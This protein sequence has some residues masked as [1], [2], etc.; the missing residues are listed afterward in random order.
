MH[1]SPEPVLFYHDDAVLLYRGDALGL[2]LLT[3]DVLVTDPPYTR[4][5]SS[6]SG[7]TTA[8][9]RAQGA[10]EAD[11]FW[12]S[13][14][15][16][17]AAQIAAH[18]KPSGCGFVFTDFRTIHLVERAFVN[19]DSGWYVGQALVWDRRSLGLGSPFR[20]SHEMIA[21]CRGPA[22][23]WHGP[24]DVANVLPFRWPYGRH[25]HHPA[26]KPL[27]LLRTLIELITEPGQVVLDLFAGSGSTLLAA[28]LAGR[29]AIGCEA[30]HAYCQV[31]SLRLSLAA[32][33]DRAAA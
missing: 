9:G 20:A 19:T 30:E 8:V 4:T 32:G 18:V 15:T 13:W 14:F 11:Q 3:A 31:A 6:H 23:R 27:G 5:G 33:E 12:L 28:R 24:R 10:L 22:F 2:P 7:R 25:P 1:A 26:E 29:R 17:I 21:F 16:D